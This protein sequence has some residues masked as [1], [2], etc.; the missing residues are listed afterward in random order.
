[1]KI[2][3]LYQGI[4]MTEEVEA[5]A[6]MVAVSTEDYLNYK[7]LFY[8]NHDLF[9]ERVNAMK[10]Y[11][12]LYLYLYL[13]FAYDAY[14]EYEQQGIAKKIYFDTFHDIVI[15]A[16]NCKRDYGEI[17]IEQYDW[18]RRHIKLELFQLGRLQYEIVKPKGD[19]ILNDRLVKANERVLN[20]HI[21]QGDPLSIE[22]CRMSFKQASEFF[23]DYIEIT[24]HSWLLSPQ[25]QELLPEESNILQFQK[26]FHVYSL[27]KNSKEAEERVFNK[28]QDNPQLYEERTK[29]Q[30]VLKRYLLQNHTVDSGYGLVKN[31]EISE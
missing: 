10:G 11:R 12:Q 8:D 6:G 14:S 7:K 3:E 16:F 22:K 5:V 9:Y 29:L 19:T 1:M 17:G 21:P 20:L 15:W 2:E 23:E 28:V 4:G 26:L 31:N 18:L 24:C 13:H 25:L 27:D 30:K